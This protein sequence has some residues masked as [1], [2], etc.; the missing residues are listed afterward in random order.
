MLTLIRNIC[1]M[2]YVR[3]IFAKILGFLLNLRFFEKLKYIHFQLFSW[4]LELWVYSI[5]ECLA[6]ATC[7]ESET[8]ATLKLSS[9]LL[10]PWDIGK[11]KHNQYQQN[12][13]LPPWEGEFFVHLQKDSLLQILRTVLI[14]G[15]VTNALLS[16]LD[17][18]YPLPP[19]PNICEYH[20][21]TQLY[22]MW[23][24]SS[25]GDGDP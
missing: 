18:E 2:I 19:S 4:G 3:Y 15:R 21:W 9:K 10:L 24:G 11:Q 14:K 20:P 13:H 1:E 25:M 12:G 5:S 23:C 22:N 7:K 6:I 16:T 17:H 8:L